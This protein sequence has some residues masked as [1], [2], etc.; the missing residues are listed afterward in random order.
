MKLLE[1]LARVCEALSIVGASRINIS[2]VNRS[3]FWGGHFIGGTISCTSANVSD[4]E[5]S[6]RLPFPFSL[7]ISL[8]ENFRRPQNP[9]ILGVTPHK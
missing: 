6:V 4:Y 5:T 9:E 3:V 2:G 8:W 1:S 7:L